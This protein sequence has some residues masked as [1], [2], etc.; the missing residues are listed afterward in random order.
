MTLA[1]PLRPDLAGPHPDLGPGSALP[2]S[3]PGRQ[4]AGHLGR[5]LPGPAH[6]GL[7]RRL[8][9][10]GVRSPGP[11]RPIRRPGPGLGRVPA[12]HAGTL[13][14]REPS[15]FKATTSVFPG[16]NSIPRPVQRPHPPFWF[17]GESLPRPSGASPAS[18][19]GGCPSPETLGIRWTTTGNSPGRLKDCAEWWRPKAGTRTR[20]TSGSAEGGTSPRARAREERDC[21]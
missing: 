9:A 19:T 10:G 2:G 17:G 15:C 7:R 5:P 6:R 20:F 4:D 16:S 13:D 1:F 21:P 8:D 18:G 12:G 3:D 11:A 14:Q